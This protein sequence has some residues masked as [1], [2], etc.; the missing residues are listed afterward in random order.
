MNFIRSL[1][2]LPIF[3]LV[4]VLAITSDE[5]TNFVLKS[6]DIRITVSVSALILALFFIGYFVGRLDG[7]FAN[8]PLRAKLRE[9][10]KANKALYKEH[11]KLNKEHE[12]LSSNFS[13]LKEDF[14]QLKISKPGQSKSFREKMSGFFKFKKD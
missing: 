5:S 10:K 7:F 13:H 9:H 12:K 2:N 6:F 11:D 3:I 14:Q 4:I 1:I 8:A